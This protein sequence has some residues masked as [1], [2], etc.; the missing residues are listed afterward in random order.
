MTHVSFQM[1]PESAIDRANAESLRI[2]IVARALSLPFGGVR[3]F[4]DATIEA[5]LH[6]NSPHRFVIYYDN[7]AHMGK[8]P[9]ADETLLQAPHKFLWD[10]AILPLRLAQDR[11]NVVW[12]PHNVIAFGLRTPAVVTIHD[13]L[14]FP[15]PEMPRREY[16]LLDTLYMRLFIPRSL[17]RARRVI[18]DS[19]WTA[20]DIRRLVRI[21]RDD[22]Q[23][24]PLAPGRLFRPQ[25]VSEQMRVRQAYHLERPYF[26]FVGITSPRKNVR[27]LIEAYAQIHN[28]VRHDLV[29]VGG[30]GYV[31]EPVDDLIRRTGLMARVHRL[32]V[33]PRT[34]LPGLY[35]AADAFVFPSLY[36]GFGL[37]PLE[38]MACGCPVICSNAT[39][40]PEVVGDAALLF[41]PRDA[42]ALANHMRTVANDPALRERLRRQG[43]ERAA[44]FSY[45]RSAA[46]LL[47]LLEEAA[48]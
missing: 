43:L 26:L 29:L 36:E 3:E 28:E 41:D 47:T 16:A 22:I 46:R 15:A 45:Q 25:P 17:R 13:L 19:R 23:V 1:E 40:L 27:M 7:P 20:A 9:V 12:F 48:G 42:T 39:S 18:A 31:N 35:S 14:Y 11:L 24:V 2:G 5:L 33:A 44:Q 21:E 30:P 6:L 32:G 34:D 38:A 37:P 8:Y 4:L 10:H